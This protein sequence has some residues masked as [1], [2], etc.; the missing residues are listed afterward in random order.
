M[1]LFVTD[2]ID[3]VRNTLNHGG[4][5]TPVGII[6]EHFL[7]VLLLLYRDIIHLQRLLLILLVEFFAQNI[8]D[9]LISLLNKLKK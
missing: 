5:K 9:L 2:G 8:D 4:S 3:G 7:L 6:D 1:T